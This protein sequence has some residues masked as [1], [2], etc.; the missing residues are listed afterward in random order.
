MVKVDR[1]SSVDKLTLFVF[2]AVTL[3]DCAALVVIFIV[4]AVTVEEVG[5][6]KEQKV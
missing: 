3:V 4:V 1:L 6:A 5:S 2:V